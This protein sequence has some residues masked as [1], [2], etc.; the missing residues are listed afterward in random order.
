MKALVYD[1][2]GRKAWVDKP[3]PEI[4]EPTDVIVRITATTICG[5]ACTS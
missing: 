3:K 5:A 1:G 2:E 4:Q